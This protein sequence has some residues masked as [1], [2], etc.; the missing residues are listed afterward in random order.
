MEESAHLTP[1]CLHTPCHTQDSIC[2]FLEDKKKN[3][4]GVFTG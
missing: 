3:Q 2:F 1:R 4:R